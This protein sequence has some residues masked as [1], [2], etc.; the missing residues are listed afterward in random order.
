MTFVLPFLLI[1]PTWLPSAVQVLP[2]RVPSSCATLPVHADAACSTGHAADPCSYDSPDCD[3]R[4]ALRAGLPC[5]GHRNR[6]QCDGEVP[7]ARLAGGRLPTRRAG[8]SSGDHL[9]V[10][11]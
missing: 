6:A 11:M 2:V 8:S 4:H 1:L 7:P 5:M 9:G 3:A 10:R